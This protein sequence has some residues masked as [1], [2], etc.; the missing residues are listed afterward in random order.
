[1][2]G[3]T[4]SL[5]DRTL[6]ALKEAAARRNRSMGSIIEESLERSGIQPYDAAEYIVAMARAKS[7]LRAADGMALAVEQTRR[8]RGGD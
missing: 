4:I 6:R 1:M 7:R 3:L 5:T 2:L 8:F